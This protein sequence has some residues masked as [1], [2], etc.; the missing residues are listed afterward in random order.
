MVTNWHP[1]YDVIC[2][3]KLQNTGSLYEEHPKALSTSTLK[4]MWWRLTAT[5]MTWNGGW[6]VA[7]LAYH[8][9]VLPASLPRASRVVCWTIVRLGEWR[10]ARNDYGCHD[11]W[12]NEHFIVDYPR[13]VHI[14]RSSHGPRA[15][16]IPYLK[17]CALIVCVAVNGLLTKD[18]R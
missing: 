6:Q 9:V 11:C 16:T 2:Y 15:L 5:Q 1:D 14:Q 3:Q 17:D 10:V 12:A 18:W 4:L 7:G 8:E 13:T